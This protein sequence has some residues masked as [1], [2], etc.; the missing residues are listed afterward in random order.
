MAHIIGIDLGT[1]NLCVAVME[2]GK[3]K[4]IKNPDMKSITPSVFSI[5]NNEIIVGDVAKRQALTNP[6]TVLSIK[7]KMGTK[8]R[9]KIKGKEWSPEQISSEFLRYVKN[10]AEKYLNEKI[11]SAVITVPAYFNDAQRNATKIAGEI[12]GLKVKR[13][14]NE[15]TAAALAYGI[16]KSD[17]EMKVLVFDLGGG[18]FDVS[19][20]ELA[21]G[22]FKV[23]STSGNNH[24]GGD[25][26]D[27]VIINW[28]VTEFG[29]EHGIDLSQDKMAMQRLKEA[30]EKTKISLSSQLS[31]PIDIPFITAQ[32]NQPVHLNMKLTRAQFD[33]MTKFLVDQTLQ[34]LKDALKE[35]KLTSQKIDRVLMVGGSTQ[36]PAVQNLVKETLN[37]EFEN[38]I[39]PY[40]V[41]ALGAAIQAGVLAG[42]VQDVLLLDVT[43]LTL[44]IETLGGVSTPLIQRNTTIP[45]S[46]HQIFSTAADNQPAVDIH[47]LQGE[48]KFAADNKTLG[49]FQL[50]DIEPAPRGIPQIEVKFNIDANGIVSVT[51][52]DKKTNKNQT[53]TIKSQETLSKEE[54]E[55]LVDEAKANQKADEDKMKNIELRNK[56]ENYIY[57]LEN[58]IKSAGDKMPAE[59]KTESEKMVKELQELLAKEDY[60]TLETKIKAIEASM[61]EVAKYMQQ[62]E[63]AAAKD[64]TTGTTT[65]TTATTEKAD[66]KDKTKKDDKKSSGK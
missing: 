52:T 32:N 20:L 1:T 6:N 38:S 59:Q 41:V 61:Q 50:S 23:L 7:R 60:E 2:N 44:G 9:I 48:R 47:V 29:K 18:T 4:V 35:A 11:D 64:G 17:H 42:N 31:V 25:D 33:K 36:I 12:A 19:I 40:K 63:A 66:K 26:F 51:A 16:D 10:Y 43:P 3:A 56:V 46:K 37:K 14:I 24:L 22:T 55:K 27:K 58:A 49:R 30:A 13:I 15:P 28:I 53:I 8:E 34:P 45:V 5:A 62:Q 57:T 54:I 39:D 65:E 21:D